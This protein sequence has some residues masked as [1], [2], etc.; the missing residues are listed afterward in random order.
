MICS[1]CRKTD[2]RPPNCCD[3][4]GRVACQECMRHLSEPGRYV[5]RPD[6]WKCKFTPKE[7]PKLII[8]DLCKVCR[9]ENTLTEDANG[10][11]VPR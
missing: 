6:E 1:I 8:R 2:V 9:A 7:E 3:K 10:S 11:A 4:C 5:L